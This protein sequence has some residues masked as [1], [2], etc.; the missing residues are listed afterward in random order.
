M[1]EQY[2]K[3]MV[4]THNHGET[5]IYLLQEV[6]ENK[7]YGFIALSATKLDKK[8]ALLIDYLFTVVNYR[9]MVF[10]DLNNKKVSDYLLEFGL[11]MALQV[12][13][14]IAIKYIL[15]EIADDKLKTFY[16]QVGFQTLHSK[17]DWMFK[18]I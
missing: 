10:V 3:Q 17:K 15:L 8:P 18:P 14:L 2:I 7:I 13:K 4:N 9:K 16:Q 6:T 12:R 11:D 5:K 1:E